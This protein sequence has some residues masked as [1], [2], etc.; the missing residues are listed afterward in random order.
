MK[1]PEFIRR[2][3]ELALEMRAVEKKHLGRIAELE[4][5]VRELEQPK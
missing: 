4:R 1:Y 5:R 3:D 2:I